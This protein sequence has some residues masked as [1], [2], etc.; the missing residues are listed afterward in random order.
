VKQNVRNLPDTDLR[1]R[2]RRQN[3]FPIATRMQEVKLYGGPMNGQTVKI[4]VGASSYSV[5]PTGNPF[6]RYTYAGKDGRATMLALRLKSRASNRLLLKII[7]HSGKDPRIE[8]EF[9]K[10]TP[11]VAPRVPAWPRRGALKRAAAH[12]GAS[13]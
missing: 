5:G 4:P 9:H 1:G 10:Q 2:I 3:Q 6:F 12:Y 8:N 13:A 11:F 7:G